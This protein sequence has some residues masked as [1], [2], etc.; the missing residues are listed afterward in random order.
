MGTSATPHPPN[1]FTVVEY[2]TG[3]EVI[4][5]HR[6]RLAHATV[7]QMFMAIEGQLER[8]SSKRVLSKPKRKLELVVNQLCRRY[9][10]VRAHEVVVTVNG[11]EPEAPKTTP[12]RNQP[13]I[14]KVIE[15]STNSSCIFAHERKF[16]QSEFARLCKDIEDRLQKTLP[17]ASLSNPNDK[18]RLIVKELKEQ[19]SFIPAG[20]VVLTINE[21]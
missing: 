9:G 8:T 11:S 16:T 14:Y 20:W 5:T 17:A 21:P 7:N 18:L 13:I 15:R 19:H 10:F 1:T 12:D 3:N 4:L 6:D 2:S